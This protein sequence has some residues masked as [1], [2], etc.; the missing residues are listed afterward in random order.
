MT[1]ERFVA[2]PYSDGGSRMYRTGDIVRW[3]AD[4][5][6]EYL[7]RA[8]EQVKVRG[9]RIELG[10]IEAQLA[11]CPGVTASAVIVRTDGP[12]NRAQ[13]VAYLVGDADDVA[14]RAQLLSVLPEF[15]VPSAFVRLESLPL[16]PSGK[17]DRKALPAP[18][19][20]AQ[21]GDLT[22]VVSSGVADLLAGH[23]ATVLG[24]PRVGVR[25]D[26]FTL[27]GDS[28]LAI[29]L[30][31]LA[32]R[33]SVVLTPRQI[34]E[35]R[36]PAAIAAAVGDVATSDATVTA[37]IGVG[38]LVPLPV[39]HRL[40]EWTGGTDR[41]NQAVLIH[42]PATSLGSITGALQAVLDHHDGLR[43]T[44]IRHDRGMWSARIEEPGSVR[45]ANL[46]E[47][48]DARGLDDSE[49]RRLVTEHSE[50]ATSRLD[51]SAGRMVSV[52]WFDCGA[53][54]LGR[55]AIVAH[56][57]VVD[58]VSWG[59]VLEDL[60][61]AWVAVEAGEPAALDAVGTSLRTF[62]R[63]VAE[64]AYSAHRFAELDHWLTVTAPG[65]QLIPDAAGDAVV[66][67]GSRRT[68]TVDGAISEAALGSVAAMVGAEG[69]DVLLAALT[70]SV[71]RWR[72]STGRSE[73]ELLV[74][75]ERHG[76]E[77]LVAGIDLSRT[78]GWFT[79]IAPMRL[80]GGIDPVDTLREVK[81]SLRAAPDGGIGYGMLRYVNAR[82][83]STLAGRSESQ[84]L[85]NYLGRTTTAGS[86]AWS[87]VAESE[88]LSTDPDADMGGPYRLIVNVVSVDSGSAPSLPGQV[89]I[90]PRRTRSHSPTAGFRPSAIWRLRP[91]VTP[92]L[93]F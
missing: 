9:F 76:R 49:L 61:M 48:V 54:S 55:L 57:L 44:L 87:L 69:T 90:C 81:E 11:L 92:G 10:E 58:G 35:L 33:D 34:F 85:F 12:S 67:G 75:L 45:A 13:V 38:E 15:M 70:M 23:F 93:P 41:F 8:D 43:Q 46:V 2:N 30:V 31:N 3:N 63:T 73:H 68:V 22:G 7:G 78:V 24:L 80:H 17:L 20:A 62:S 84:I 72:R 4:G 60:A 37:D 39:V 21:V 77:E 64:H 79:T 52:V 71:D 56:H 26:F 6:L 47:R 83:A 1:S 5:V 32:R 51:P 86:T 65:A 16:S 18:D 53:E 29:R 89:K 91:R 28:I 59:T 88:A 14:V 66:S 19:F 25:D 27:G 50:T 40:S 42:S 36:T 82:T 74:D